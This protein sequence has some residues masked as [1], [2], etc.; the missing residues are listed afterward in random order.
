MRPVEKSGRFLKN[1]VEGA[2]AKAAAIQGELREGDVSF[3]DRGRH[4]GWGV[5]RESG[6]YWA[7][8]SHDVDACTRY[9]VER[10]NGVPTH[11]ITGRCAEFRWNELLDQLEERIYIA[12]SKVRNL[13]EYS[14]AL[15]G[16]TG[17][18]RSSPGVS[19]THDCDTH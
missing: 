12:T 2:P 8:R 17:I 18:R 3:I 13:R 4:Y 16:C 11:P 15:S 7:D 9:Q 14:P 1:H 5:L 6:A 19:P 10:R